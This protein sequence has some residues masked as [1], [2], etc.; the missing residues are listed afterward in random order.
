MPRRLLP[1][2]VFRFVNI[3]EVVIAP[4]G[5]AIAAILVRRNRGTDRRVP[6]LHVWNGAWHEIAETEG[7][8]TPRWS[9]CGSRLGFLRRSGGTASLNVL[10]LAS[11]APQTLLAGPAALRE[12]AWSP[13]GATLAFQRQEALPQ[14]DWLRLPTP[15]EGASWA[16]PVFVTERTLYRHD[17]VGLLPEAVWQTFT[18]P[19]AGGAPTRITEGPWFSGFYFPP[20]LAF[21]PD[22]TGLILA[23]S[24]AA[25]WDRTPNEIPI[26]HID[27]ASR[28]VTQLTHSPGTH[29][30]PTL[31]PD[32]ATLAYTAVIE[33]KLS[34]QLR[35]LFLRDMATG[36]V[37]ELLPNFD[38]PVDSLHWLADSSGL[39]FCA[40]GPGYRGALRAGMNGDVEELAT[41]LA[42]AS[43]EMPYQGGTVSLA[44]DG[45]LAYAR[46]AID[47]PGE[48]VR[49]S[50]GGALATLLTPN[51]LF[52][53]EIGG[54][55]PAETFHTPS[56][57]DGAPIQAWLILPPGEAPAQGW[58]VILEIHGGP[59][60]A[61][62]DRFSIKHQ[63]LAAAGYAVVFANPRG[64]VGY[65][66]AFATALHH[67]FPGPDHADL[68][69]VMDAVVARPEIDATRQFITG[70][71]GGGVLTL[72]AV[73]HTTR[74]RAAVSIKP[75]VAW[76]SWM[77][78]ADIGPSV[79]VTWMN[80]Q[81][82]WTDGETF[83]ALSPLTHLP[84][85]T[86]P[87]MVMA[88]EADSR[89]PI[90]EAEQA[91]A[92]LQMRGIPSALVRIPGASHSTGVARPSHVAAEVMAG[93]SWF[94]RF[95]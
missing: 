21:T 10:E 15:P 72:W 20:G 34:G 45:S 46:G 62:G 89:T 78:T 33:R 41:D 66:E 74:F 1:E 26:Q 50:A 86:T 65:G 17:T 60:A 6:S 16:P 58:P 39:I 48:I 29:A 9:P 36:T 90:S 25:D 28:T 85:A 38:R 71:S 23:A 76:E 63:M 94:E 18:L 54:F 57:A 3:A 19:A 64:S 79:G 40:D 4:D 68:M 67:R 8:S 83:R 49:R 14:P 30:N 35:R 88:G 11:L 5:G 91:Y 27:L 80:Q 69:D 22:G 82:P 84:R 32:G 31:S 43:I 56:S 93:L 42:S 52:A 70:V 47:N 53:R 13:D 77:L 75:V 59:Y 87:T 12:L 2:D 44:R 51:A 95:K 81:T 61:Y 37:R 92:C 7:A 24:R 55:R 73:S